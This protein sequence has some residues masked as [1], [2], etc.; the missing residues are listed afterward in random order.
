MTEYKISITSYPVLEFDDL[1]TVFG[2]EQYYRFNIYDYIYLY[3]EKDISNITCDNEIDKLNN[4]LMPFL[5]T[6][7]NCL[8]SNEQSKELLNEYIKNLIN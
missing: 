1:P 2:N 4:I 3:K 5:Y 7:S 6:K 8:D